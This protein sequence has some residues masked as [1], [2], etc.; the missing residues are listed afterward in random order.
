MRPPTPTGPT[1]PDR[2]SSLVRRSPVVFDATPVA[3]EPRTGWQVVTAYA[4]ERDGPWLVD[5]SHRARWDLQDRRIDEHRPFGLTV[6][7]T[8][9]EVA[10]ENGLM[11]N[12][13]NRTQS[14]IWHVGP[15]PAPRMP[16]VVS[17]TDTTD[18]HAW[19]A[20]VGPAAPAVLERVSNLD[21][22]PPGRDMPF[23]TQG[24]VLHVPCQ[25]VT[26]AADLVLVACSRGYGRTFAEALFHSGADLGLRPAGEA[27]FTRRVG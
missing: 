23:L 21:L 19:L 14:A 27:V 20:I 15:G 2:F 18:S 17:Y 6:P 3:T 11:I 25:V 8:P 1:D 4:D 24:P 10:V 26:W 16:A 13:M 9:G 22:F 12:R 5:L 7:G